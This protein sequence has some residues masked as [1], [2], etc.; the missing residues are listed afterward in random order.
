MLANTQKLGTITLHCSQY[1]KV[2][3]VLDG[4]VDAVDTY[5]LGKKFNAFLVP[6]PISRL[7][8]EKALDYIFH[9]G[10][11]SKVEQRITVGS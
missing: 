6:E 11:A 10:P 5:K 2:Y 3:H 4:R 7:M 1:T 9:V 8:Y